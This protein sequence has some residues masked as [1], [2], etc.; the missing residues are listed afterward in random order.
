[1]AAVTLVAVAGVFGS[2][3]IVKVLVVDSDTSLVPVVIAVVV[4]VS[5]VKLV[6]G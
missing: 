4:V 6:I 1:M 2:V 3:L 5:G